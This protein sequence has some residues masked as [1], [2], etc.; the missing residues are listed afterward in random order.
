M[1]FKP[2]KHKLIFLF[3]VMI[4][5]IINLIT[6]NSMN[7][8]PTCT[9][10]WNIEKQTIE[11]FGGSGAFHQ[12]ANL[13]AYPEKERNQV[14]DLLFSQNN[15]I[16]LSIVRNIIGDGGDWGNSIDGATPSIEP[17]EEVWN[18]DGDEDQIWLMNEAKKRGC[19]RFVS[20][21][22]SPPAWMKT[23]NSVI[24]GGALSPDKYQAFAD[25]LSKYVQGY[26][27][28]HNIDIHAISPANEPGF[29]APYS[30]CLWT[31]PQ[32]R[33]FI[34]N[35]LTPTLKR[36]NVDARVIIPEEMNFSEDYAIDT[37]NDPEAGQGVD[38]I[39]THAYDFKAK[40]F[41]VAKSQNKSIWQTEVSNIGF[42]DG[43]INDGLKYAKLLHD[44]MTITEVNAWLFWW[45]VAY[46][47]GETLIHLDMNFKTFQTFKRLYT[48]GNYSRFVRPGYVRVNTDSNPAAN[49]FVTAYKDN[50][51]GKFA[52]VAINNGDQEQTIGFNLKEFPKFKGIIPYRTSAKENLAK[53]DRIPVSKNSFNAQLKTK[54]VTTF[55]AAEN[56]LPGELS[57]REVLTPIEAENFDDQSDIKLE[58]CNEGGST[59]VFT[60]KGAFTTYQN[61]NFYN[62]AAT[63][64]LRIAVYGRGKLELLLDSPTLGTPIGKYS[65]T[66]TG[67][68]SGSWHKTAWETVSIPV[69]KVRGV[70]DFYVVFTPWDQDSTCK[71]NWL[72]FKAPLKPPAGKIMIQMENQTVDTKTNQITPRFKIVNSGTV[73]VNLEKV[74][75]RYFYTLDSEAPQ[76]FE[77]SGGSIPS[78]AVTGSIV[79][80]KAVTPQAN[81]CLEIGFNNNAGSL[82]P[83]QEADFHGLISTQGATYR[84]DN[85]FSFN[86][87]QDG[88]ADWE[89]VAGYI[90]DILCWGS[91]PSLLVNPGFEDG[92]AAGWFNFGGPSK[93]TV[94]NETA[95][96]G[97]Y[98]LLITNRNESWQGVAQDLMNVMKPGLTYEVSAWIKLKN[99]PR[100]AGRISVK[101]TDNRGDN[102]TW[103]ESKTVSDE[104]WTCI[105]GLYELKAAGELKAL[106]LYTEGPEPGTEYYVDNVAVREVQAAN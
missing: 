41:P 78:S 80:M 93:I 46:K 35:H 31:G 37:L 2:F 34:K 75:L 63:C 18:W 89:A 20:T 65:F 22:W 69:E 106:Q 26:Q 87:N 25:Y 88:L 98:C 16:G 77:F 85:D 101:R 104:E 52:I 79:K 13:M 68:K 94:T 9:V 27:E 86:P 17:Q 8:I 1:N 62:G 71:L 60:K 38:I 73:P 40:P 5:F 55:I 61:Y 53:L 92:T 96:T 43:S 15:G 74:K 49:V 14:L 100:D 67:K 50:S 70:K 36:D 57:F 83:K 19:T 97:T 64:D 84:Q 44:H 10:N 72:E 66:A 54:S 23:N 6:I 105:S 102:Y 30:S 56:E 32:F 28:H 33:D 24:K 11:G 3:V 4:F 91:E 99:K 82:E 90:D 7:A 103:I 48:I 76:R 42:N 51:S 59:I 29:T 45:L 12:S 21:V 47:E 95:Q 81:F 58:G 39:G